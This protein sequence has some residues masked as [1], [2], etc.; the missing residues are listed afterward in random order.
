MHFNVICEISYHVMHCKSTILRFGQSGREVQL[1]GNTRQ[2]NFSKCKKP[3]R[4][5]T[6]VPGI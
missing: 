3:D 2:L 5:K 1:T 4:Y 6:E